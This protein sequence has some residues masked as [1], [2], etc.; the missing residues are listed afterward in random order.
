MVGTHGQWPCLWLQSVPYHQWEQV[1]G[2]S[3]VPDEQEVRVVRAGELRW[4]A[5]A[6]RRRDAHVGAVAEGL[7]PTAADG[8]RAVGARAPHVGCIGKESEIVNMVRDGLILE[9]RRRGR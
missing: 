6:R 9:R 3:Q 5:S 8:L 4:Q 1:V 2:R 7:R